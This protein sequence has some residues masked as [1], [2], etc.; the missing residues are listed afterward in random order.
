MYVD[1]FSSI[2]LQFHYRYHSIPIRFYVA[3]I[4]TCIIQCLYVF[5]ENIRIHQLKNDDG[6]LLEGGGGNTFRNM[7]IKSKTS[8]YIG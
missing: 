8:S 3:N 5:S 2:L 1:P 4:G 6:A 7:R